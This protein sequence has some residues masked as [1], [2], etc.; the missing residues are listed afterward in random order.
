[1]IYKSPSPLPRHVRVVFE[2]PACRW[3]DQIFLV[4]DFNGWNTYATPMFP[5]H[6]GIW[7]AMVDLP[8]GCW[9]A[10][11]YLVDGRWLTD[12]HADGFR[13]NAYG[14]E[15]SLVD[16]SLPAEGLVLDRLRSQVWQGQM[17]DVP[18]QPGLARVNT[19]GDQ[20]PKTS[21][22][23]SLTLTLWQTIQHKRRDNG[24]RRENYDGCE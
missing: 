20:L 18:P 4:G 16:A 12:A 14:T 21:A 2:L 23:K 13:P 9:Y 10:F 5:D 19:E 24:G 6:D 7:R 8:D 1:M 22:L 15:N 17:G 3:A 11:R